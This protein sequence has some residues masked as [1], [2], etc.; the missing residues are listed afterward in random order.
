[1]KRKISVLFLTLV[2]SFLLFSCQNRNILLFLN[3]GEYVDESILEEFEQMYHCEVVMDLTDSN[4][5]FYSKVRSG[6]TCYDV[7]APSDYMVEKMYKNDMLQ[8]IDWKSVPNYSLPNR[9][10]GVCGIAEELEKRAPGISDYYVPY[11][12]GT[13]GMMYSTKKEGLKEAITTADNEWACLFDRNSLPAGTRV[14]MYNSSL[15]D[16]YAICK[17]LGLDYGVE[18]D[19]EEL[20]QIYTVIKNMKYEAWGTDD[21]KKDIVAGNRDLGFM[22]TGDFLYYYCE[23]AA[24]TVMDAYLA[25]DVKVED[26]P[27]MLKVITAEGGIYKEKYRIGF[28]IFIPKDTIAFCDNLVITKDARH[29]ELACQFIDFMCSRDAGENHVDPAYS[30]TYYVSYNT[31]YL[32]VYDDILDL[33]SLSFTNED[34]TL[35][36]EE[37][38][39]NSAYD[40]TLYWNA[41]DIAIGLAFE[42]YYPKEEIVVD[43][44]GN[45]KNYKGC[46]LAAFSRKYIDTINTTFNDARASS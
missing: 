12:W 25:G 3:W 19:K 44:D 30:N 21:I 18:L 13:W 39:S 2:L 41:Y 34:K 40:T 29:Y 28:D 37:V 33:Q 22:W 7:V 38:Q 32:D 36:D 8:K 4:E 23:N 5:K 20:N 24:N 45:T 6:T 9:M 11:L 43:E 35:F 10:A 14:A 26:I 17:Y 46:I 42:K 1:M 16:Y 15:H 27:E 31:P